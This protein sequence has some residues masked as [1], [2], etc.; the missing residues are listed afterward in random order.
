MARLAAAAA[1]A[2]FIGFPTIAFAICDDDQWHWV[3]VPGTQC[4]D[5]SPTGFAYVCFPELGPQAPLVVYF[6]GGGGCFDA[7]TCA[8]ENSCTG[9]GPYGGCCNSPTATY[10]SDH[11]DR[12]YSCDGQGWGTC[13]PKLSSD[14]AQS[15][16]FN[17][18]TSAFND[19]AIHRWNFV[20]IPYCTGDGHI[21]PGS[22]HDFVDPNN[23]AP[24]TA[25]INGFPNVQHDIAAL[26][27]LGFAPSK[28][29][30]WGSSAGGFGAEC[31]MQ[32]WA[33]SFPTA[34]QMFAMDNSMPGF[35]PPFAPGAASAN[36]FWG[37]A[38]T[39]PFVLAEGDTRVGLDGV[40]RYNAIN[41]PNVRKGFTDD[42]R[43]YAVSGFMCFLGASPEPNGTCSDA[44]L[45]TLQDE[46]RDIMAGNGN[47]KFFYHSSNCHAEKEGDGNAYQCKKAGAVGAPCSCPSGE[48]ECHDAIDCGPTNDLC[49]WDPG[50][51]NYD[52]MQEGGTHFND[53]VRGLM[54]I[55]GYDWDNVP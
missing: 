19:G 22:T 47:S 10:I 8:C 9:P 43:D 51:C 38:E 18:P 25:H 50:N 36:V 20:D 14:P 15:A 34:L 17:G 16:A 55:P 49:A 53:W 6:E 39:C 1:L 48:A 45:R 11:W 31:G 2:W 30:L 24:Y 4:L 37:L 32:T 27:N 13:T 12:S 52:D 41:L 7:A 5:G 28:L 42:Y 21:G 35:Y 33:Q 29:A 54:Q 44:T 46:T 40:M 26:Q 3:D 23:G